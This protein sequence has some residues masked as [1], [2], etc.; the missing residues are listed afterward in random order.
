MSMEN[1]TTSLDD[2]LK[3]KNMVKNENISSINIVINMLILSSYFCKDITYCNIKQRL[4]SNVII[5]Y[6]ENY[7]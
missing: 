7:D 5:T 4:K 1:E 2:I 6:V 3:I